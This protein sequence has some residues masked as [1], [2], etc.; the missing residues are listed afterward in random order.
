MKKNIA[1]INTKGGVGKSTLA[2]HILPYLLKDKLFQLIEIDDNNQTIDSYTNSELLNNKIKSVKIDQGTEALET[3]VVESMFDNDLITIIDAGGGNDSRIVIQSLIDHN[4]A[5]DTLFVIPYVPD[6]SQLHNLFETIELVQNYNHIVVC[7][8]FSGKED[9]AFIH[10]SEDFEIPNIS[11]LF[12]EKFSVVPK[13]N[14]FGYATAYEKNTIYDFA[15]IAFDFDQQAILNFAKI[16]TNGDKDAM[17]A[18]YRR[19]KRA[20]LAKKYLVDKS[21]LKLGKVIDDA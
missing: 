1:I 16:E 20:N 19:W 14:L 7:N 15:K 17:L 9:E 4:L 2:Y 3:L 10:G 21:I 12:H 11:Q 18:I 6:F 13:T 8:N 5:S